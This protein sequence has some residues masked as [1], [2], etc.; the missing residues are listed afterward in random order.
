MSVAVNG[1]AKKRS[2]TSRPSGRAASM[3]I[4]VATVAAAAVEAMVVDAAVTTVAT[5]VGDAVESEVAATCL[6]PPVF[7][8]RPNL[9][10]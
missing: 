7:P 9:S 5:V 8:R 4:A 6:S 3:A 10:T 1:A 2:E